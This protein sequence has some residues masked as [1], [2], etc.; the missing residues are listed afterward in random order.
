MPIIDWFVFNAHFTPLGLVIINWT[1]C[2]WS[3]PLLNGVNDDFKCKFTFFN[4]FYFSLSKSVLFTIWRRG[5]S[6][7]LID[8]LLKV[9]STGEAVSP[10]YLNTS[11]ILFR[12][13]ESSIK[14][15]EKTQKTVKFVPQTSSVSSPA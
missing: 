13:R 2:L 10:V 6:P 11:K 7:S 14:R 8:Q 4:F 15:G 3:G 1:L 9:L 5:L 12:K